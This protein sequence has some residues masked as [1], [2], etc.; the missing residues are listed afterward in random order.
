MMVK[1]KKQKS[2]SISWKKTAL[3][4]IIIWLTF[5]FIA[6]VIISSVEYSQNEKIKQICNNP[7]IMYESCG[8]LYMAKRICAEAKE[9]YGLNNCSE[10]NSWWDLLWIK[11]E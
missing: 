4:I 7:M 10:T 1:K 8:D 5:L 11:E 6:H 2:E 9:Q 3:I